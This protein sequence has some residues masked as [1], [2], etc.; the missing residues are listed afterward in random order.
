M[1][2][3]TNDPLLTFE[4]LPGQCGSIDPNHGVLDAAWSKWD[5]ART[6]VERS[7]EIIDA[8]RTV[9]EDSTEEQAYGDDPLFFGALVHQ[10]EII[11]ERRRLIHAALQQSETTALIELCKTATN[12]VDAPDCATIQIGR[13]NVILAQW[14]ENTVI[15]FRNGV[16]RPALPGETVV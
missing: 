2:N 6:K 14:G 4:T 5:T 8:Y 11:L 1:A 3:Q 13:G 9:L 12:L 7:V 15:L 16:H 10:V